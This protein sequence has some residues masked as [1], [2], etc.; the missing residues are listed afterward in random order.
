MLE[1]GSYSESSACKISAEGNLIFQDKLFNQLD[2]WLEYYTHLKFNQ[3]CYF[4]HITGKDVIV[5]FEVA[6][7]V[8]RRV[9]KTEEQLLVE[10]YA[11]LNIPIQLEQVWYDDEDCFFALSKDKNIPIY[12]AGEAQ[13]DF[14][15]ACS[16]FTDDNFTVFGKTFSLP[17]LYENSH[18][19][20][21]DFWGTKYSS[22]SW[23]W[24]M[25]GAHPYLDTVLSQTKLMKSNIL[26]LGA[27]RSH[28]AAFFAQHGHIVTAIDISAKAIEEAKKLYP[29][30]ANL[31][32][33]QADVFSY[34]APNEGYDLI[35][36]HTFYCAIPPEQR[37][38]LVKAWQNLLND[39]GK[40]AG[41]FFSM[42]KPDGPPY[43]GSE[44]ELQ[45][46]IK[47]KFQNLFWN[48]IRQGP[49]ERLGKEFFCY[50]Q[51]I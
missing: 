24:D 9:R 41:V 21:E 10:L 50:T 48:R 2:V 18:D 13:N 36:D 1:N 32:Y 46:R 15:N 42:F 37:N 43:G 44:W 7:L 31:K 22:Q 26:V 16:S 3:G 45:Q 11:G 27:G 28:D 4:S 8:A 6:P 30:T 20:S 40:L 23:G 49:I 51:K 29:E 19:N 47:G 33:V 17:Y 25:D 5:E 38:Q 35:W 39:E 14:F 12:I 34:K